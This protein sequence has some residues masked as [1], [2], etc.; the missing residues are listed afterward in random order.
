MAAGDF[1]CRGADLRRPRRY[2]RRVTP[3]ELAD[4]DRA[5]VAKDITRPSRKPSR[6]GE[7]LAVPAP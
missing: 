1:P 4:V 5:C 3:E 6:I 2:A 7:T